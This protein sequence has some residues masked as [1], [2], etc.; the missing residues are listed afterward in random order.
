MKSI[1]AGFVWFVRP[2]AVAPKKLSW[3]QDRTEVAEGSQVRRTDA[4]EG[5]RK[6]RWS[7]DG[8]EQLQKVTIT[9]T[10]TAQTG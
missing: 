2:N 7:I 1:M 8:L 6:D 3:T 9:A 4:V 5:R 10:E